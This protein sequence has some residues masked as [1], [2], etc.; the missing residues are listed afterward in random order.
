MKKNIKTLTNLALIST[1]AMIGLAVM[2][3][4]M[5]GM[6]GMTDVQTIIVLYASGLCMGV[7]CAR[8]VLVGGNDDK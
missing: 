1:G 3:A 4:W 6:Y 7:I 5:G 8:L 2:W